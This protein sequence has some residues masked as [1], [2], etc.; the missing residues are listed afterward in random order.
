MPDSHVVCIVGGACAGS[1]AANMFAEAGIEVVLLE[2]NSKPYGKVEDGLPR[3]HKIQRRKEYDMIDSLLVHPNIHYVP[4]T[5]LGEHY[6]FEELLDW[7]FTAL[8]FANGAWKDRPVE[9]EGI[10]DYIDKGLVYQNPFIYWFNHMNEKAYDGPSY[11]V[12]DDMGIFGGGLSSIDC[13]KAV[14]C[15]LYER[16]LNE[17]G[18]EC[19]LY[20]LEHKGI[21]HFCEQHDIDPESLGIKGCTLYYRRRKYDMPLASQKDRSE[22]A[23]A[24]AEATRAKILDLAM[25]KYRFTYAERHLA[26]D[27]IIENDRLVGVVFNRTRVDGRKAIPLPGTEVE[28]RHPAWI[29]SIGSVPEPLDGVEMTGAFY[30]FE[31]WDLGVYGPR[32]NVYGVGNAVTGQ[33]NIVVSR[34][35]AQAVAEHLIG[36]WGDS[37]KLPEARVGEILEKVKARQAEVGYDGD[38]TAWI[39]KVIPEDLE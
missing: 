20:D 13:A 15:L 18:V 36:Q 7:G 33:G 17:R 2:Q 34:K 32:E 27:K 1:A 23:R 8:I 24:K 29:S 19:T 38:Y 21:T 26:K 28:K 22:E 30:K 12:V 14:Q 6:Q 39:E 35:H 9:V 4:L 16:A 10:D 11:E 37:D 31:D 5:R 25:E 3:W